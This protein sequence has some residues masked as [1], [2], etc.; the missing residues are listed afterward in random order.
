MYIAAMSAD[1]HPLNLFLDHVHRRREDEP[2]GAL[3]VRFE[4]IDALERRQYVEQR[5]RA[6]KSDAGRKTPTGR[7][8]RVD[9]GI[10]IDNQVGDTR[11]E[12]RIFH[13]LLYIFQASRS[14]VRLITIIRAGAGRTLGEQHR[15]IRIAQRAIQKP[16]LV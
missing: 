4:Q 8:V 2:L 9:A 10:P 15:F 5:Y 14:M 7:Q 11:S 3:Y 13:E 16:M 1:M 6:D 12:V